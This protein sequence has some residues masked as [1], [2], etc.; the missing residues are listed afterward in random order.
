LEPTESTFRDIVEISPFPVYVCTGDDMIIS[1]ANNATLK[2]WDR[3]S[4]VIGKPFFEALP[5]LED[6]PF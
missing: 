6:Q 5:E 2:A 3:D 1:V 4:S